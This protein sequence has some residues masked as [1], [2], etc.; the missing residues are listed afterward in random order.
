MTYQPPFEDNAKIDSLCM[1]IAELV[2]MVRP[3]GDFA[4]SP[5]L[6]RKLRIKT[7][8]SSLLIEGNSLDELAVTAIIS[9]K[10]VLGN[11]KD[12]REVEN[13][14]RA[15]SLIPKLDPYSIDD[16]LKA[17]KVM[18]DGMIPEAG[19][20][21]S[22]NVGVFD[23]DVLV[24]AGTPA[25]YVPEVMADIFG[26]LRSTKVHPLLA[27]CIFHFE[28][29]FCHPFSDGNGRTGRLWHTLLLSKWRSVLAWLPVE[30]TIRERQAGYYQ[31]LARSNARGSS[32][33]FVEFMLEAIRDAILP[34]ALS[35]EIATGDD[36]LIL[37]NLNDD[38][39]GA[40]AD[41]EGNA[42]V[43]T[44]EESTTSSVSVTKAS[45]EYFLHRFD[46]DGIG[47]RDGDGY[48]DGDSREKSSCD[49]GAP[50]KID[51]ISSQTAKLA[52]EMR[53]VNS[54][55]VIDPLEYFKNNPKGTIGELAVLM[56]CSK[57][58]AE[59]VVA[60]LKDSGRLERRGSA[61]GG[62]WVVTQL[63]NATAPIEDEVDGSIAEHA[64][65]FDEL[66]K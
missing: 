20:F 48:R 16:L 62:A 9:G 54:S 61:R 21:R 23:G 24:H 7:I 8:H 59:R 12:I 56:G 36:L 3:Q 10:R 11:A 17:H 43:D 58:T 25:A 38:S 63:A 45:Y 22:G 53:G 27:S 5:K 47:L 32:E 37:G 57:R 55:T 49:T 31:A 13:A 2:G 26:W 4:R 30:S 51:G 18:M 6:H 34:F 42:A 39:R 15:Y 41:D 33:A 60:A 40:G 65:V 50:A 35:D 46:G 44:G 66:S 64:D 52:A 1:E 14:Q 19:M 29:E 28:F